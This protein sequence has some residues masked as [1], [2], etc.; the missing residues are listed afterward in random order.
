MYVGG[1]V[2]PN[3]RRS[4]NPC[5][6]YPKVADIHIFLFDRLDTPALPLVLNCLMV[7]ALYPRAP[8]VM[9]GN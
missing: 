6:L 5:D 1:A 9:E 8:R 2:L 7:N 4:Y 3:K